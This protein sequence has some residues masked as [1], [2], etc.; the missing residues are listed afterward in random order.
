MCKESRAIAI[1][2]QPNTLPCK[3]SQIRFKMESDII[4][5]T[6]F[7]ETISDKISGMM[8]S[9]NGPKAMAS[10]KGTR[11]QPHPGGGSGRLLSILS[12]VL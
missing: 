7:G 4:Y 6:K 12:S 11:S 3:D 5:I 2:E 8:I 9:D 1:R 10:L